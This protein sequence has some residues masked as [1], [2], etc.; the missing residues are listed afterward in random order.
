MFLRQSYG[1]YPSTSLFYSAIYVRI[2]LNIAFLLEYPKW[3]QESEVV[4]LIKKLLI[5]F[6]FE[7][8]S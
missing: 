3:N 5:C 2:K 4:I 8:N 1:G 6:L 7:S